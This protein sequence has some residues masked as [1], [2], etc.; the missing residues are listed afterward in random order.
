MTQ[1]PFGTQQPF[2][3]GAIT[4]QQRE[5]AISHLQSLYANGTLGEGQF[6]QRLDLAFAARDRAELSR[7]LQGLARI[8]P[9]AL[10][11]PAPGQPTPAENVAGGLTHLSGLVTSFIGPAIVR[12]LATPGSKLWWESSRAF[13]LQLT[14]FALGVA[15]LV[16]TTILGFGG[17]I[18]TLGWLAWVGATVFASVRAFNGR[19]G[20]DGFGHLLLAR[21]KAPQASLGYTR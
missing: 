17:G 1:Q 19:P 18:M 7:A 3:P 9:V 12:A 15:A 11:R 5:R 21:P 10:T 14:A 20:T 16:L 2:H 8:A 6:N 4:E 13:S